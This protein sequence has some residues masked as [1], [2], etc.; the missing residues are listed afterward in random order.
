MDVRRLSTK[1]QVVLLLERQRDT[2]VSGAEM[3]DLLQISRNAIWKAIQDLR[4]DGYQIEAVTNKGY[5]LVAEN[6]IISLEGLRPY[7]NEKI[8][9][10]NVHV[11]DTI[12]STNKLAKEMAINQAQHGTIIIANAQTQ[13]R[14]RYGR[15]FFSPAD[16]GIYLSL[17][18]HAKKLPVTEP[19]LTTIFTANA[20]VDAIMTT[21]HVKPQIKWVN[22]LILNN[23]KVCGILTE[24]V[25]D[26]ESG[27]IEW[28]VVGIGINFFAETED[29]P[30]DLQEIAG[31]LFTEKPSIT[32]NQLI[33]TIIENLLFP[34]QQNLD[35]LITIYRNHLIILNQHVEVI[36][37]NT[38]YQA[39]AR[40]ID[41]QGRLLVEKGD[42]SLVALSSGE[43][44]VNRFF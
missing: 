20:V 6:D 32:R 16:S 22:D 23:R 21:A 39:I 36:A 37:G 30:T 5:R 24:A 40:D 1:K 12:D 4:K 3:A 29:F 19:T 42:G 41:E 33:A 10:E 34:E 43:V 26:F 11:F 14:G 8:K 18:L 31:A 44:K 25:T 28:I 17:I 2:F 9:S 27:G 15:S 7:L 13:G 38:T 35:N